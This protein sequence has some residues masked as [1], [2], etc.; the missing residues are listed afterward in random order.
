MRIY[1]LVLSGI[2][3]QIIYRKWQNHITVPLELLAGR[4]INQ[5][6][7]EDVQEQASRRKLQ[8]QL[9]DHVD[10]APCDLVPCDSED[11]PTECDTVGAAGG[12]TVMLVNDNGEGKPEEE[13]NA[14]HTE[15]CGHGGADTARR[16]KCPDRSKEAAEGEHNA[17][18][19]QA[20]ADD[21]EEET[22]SGENRP[23][24]VLMQVNMD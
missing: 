2:P 3:N 19:E 21:A 13:S 23:F 10:L 22:I 11:T 24:P 14:S 9:G 16:S 6:Q 4:N 5:I 8:E 20:D 17:N 1:V 18:K 12:T 7:E 15:V